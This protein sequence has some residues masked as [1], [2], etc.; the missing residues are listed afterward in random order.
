MLAMTLW[1]TGC[2]HELITPAFAEELLRKG[3]RWRECIPL[4]LQHGNS[5]HVVAAAPASRQICANIRLVHKGLIYEQHD[6]WLY[7]YDGAL[8]DVMLSED[9]LNKIPC[10]SEPGTVL[11]DTKQR[12]GDIELLVESMR[13]YNTLVV[14]RVRH[15]GRRGS[16]RKGG[17]GTSQHGKRRRSTCRAHDCNKDSRVKTG[18]GSATHATAT[19]AGQTCVQ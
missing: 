6:V 3:A 18:D 16:R 11:L 5:E 10:I 14:N 17:D 7:V 8:P 1:D 2:S 12:A 13:D 19:S 9:F 4:H 15:P